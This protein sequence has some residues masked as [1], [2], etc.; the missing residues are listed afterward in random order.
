MTARDAYKHMLKERVGPALRAFGFRGSGS[1]WRLLA[2]NGD[3]AIVNAQGSRYSTRDEVL[4]YVNV[5]VVPEPWWAWVRSRFPGTVNASAAD[6]LWHQR[7]EPSPPPGEHQLTPWWS[8]QDSASAQMCGDELCRRLA[9]E[10]VPRLRALLDRAVLRSELRENDR[11][12][13]ILLV[14]EGPN[15]A[16]NALIEGIEP[17]APEYADWL[18]VRSTTRQRR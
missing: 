2:D 15:D 6:G 3:I 9:T 5:A 8:V 14:D 7:L 13:A 10:S 16:L 12:V 18:R 11:A 1:T 4:F 17:D